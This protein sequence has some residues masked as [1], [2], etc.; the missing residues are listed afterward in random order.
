MV[1]YIAR[2]CEGSIVRLCFVQ[3]WK[4]LRC[5]IKFMNVILLDDKL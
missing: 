3:G 5:D 4:P 1:S 2:T